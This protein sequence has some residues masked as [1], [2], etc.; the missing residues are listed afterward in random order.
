LID[1]T[2]ARFVSSGDGRN[3]LAEAPVSREFDRRGDMV[4]ENEWCRKSLELLGLLVMYDFAVVDSFALEMSTEGVVD[5]SLIQITS[6]PDSVI[7]E[8]GLELMNDF[9]SLYGRYDPSE[10]YWLSDDWN[11]SELFEMPDKKWVD[12]LSNRNLLIP[13]TVT[14]SNNSPARAFFYLELAERAGV[15]LLLSPQ[16]DRCVTT[17]R[18]KLQQFAHELVV[19]KVETQLQGKIDDQVKGLFSRIVSVPLPPVSRMILRRAR[20]EK[21]SLLDVAKEIRDSTEA[22]SFRKWLAE[23]NKVLASGYEAG[24]VKAH[25]E[26][27]KLESLVDGW[28]KTGDVKEGIEYERRKFNIGEIPTIGWIVKM[29]GIDSISVNDPILN[30]NRVYR[31]I[32]QWYSP[33]TQSKP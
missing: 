11:Q 15:P 13:T 30:P 8:C 25:A 9:S 2:T 23:L 22:R 5:D 32:S 4:R 33:R 18:D 27:D 6:F 3:F 1:G 28:L 24:V 29:T 19:A 14:N 10:L 12:A 20:E 7:V 17:G 21:R 31:F 16:K 26:L